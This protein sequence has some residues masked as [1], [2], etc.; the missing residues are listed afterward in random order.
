MRLHTEEQIRSAREALKR[1]GS[2]DAMRKAGVRGDDGVL[3]LRRPPESE[4]G[5]TTMRT[6]QPAKR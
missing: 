2:W 1:Y 5:V 4:P 6:V 3:Y